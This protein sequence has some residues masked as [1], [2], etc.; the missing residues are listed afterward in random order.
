MNRLW[1]LQ[2]T[3]SEYTYVL[4]VNTLSDLFSTK[5]FIPY[6]SHT[7]LPSYFMLIQFFRLW[8]LFLCFNKDQKQA[9]KR[10]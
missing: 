7:Q 8:S 6:V 2:C 9:I 10:L 5:N 3:C 4:V 1:V